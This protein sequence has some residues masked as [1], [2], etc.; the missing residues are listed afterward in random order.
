MLLLSC[1]S[2]SVS[3]AKP[4]NL[5]KNYCISVYGN[6]TILPDDVIM[7]TRHTGRIDGNRD[8]NMVGQREL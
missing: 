2:L 3:L 6:M 5:I 4:T 8:T 7:M 1:Q